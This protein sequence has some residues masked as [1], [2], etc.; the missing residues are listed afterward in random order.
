MGNDAPSK[1]PEGDSAERQKP[2]ETAPRG[3]AISTQGDNAVQRKLEQQTS[4]AA[5]RGTRENDP[6][7]TLD[8]GDGTVVQDRRPFA[9]AAAKPASDILATTKRDNTNPLTGQATENVI[10][11]RTVADKLQHFAI[12]AAAR[13]SNPEGQR[14][15]VQGCVDNVVGIAEGLNDAK[16]QTKSAAVVGAK[17][18]N[19]G[20]EALKDGSVT[21]FLMQ[22]NA[23]N[24]P[25]FKVVASSMQEML[26]AGAKDPDAFNKALSKLGEG[27]MQANDRYNAMSPEQ[28]GHV[29]GQVM[30]GGWTPEVSGA[31]MAVATTTTRIVDGV[32][33]QIDAAVWNR[34]GLVVKDIE[35]LSQNSPKMALQGKQLLAQLAQKYHFSEQELAAVGMPKGFLDG[36]PLGSNNVN[37]QKYIFLGEKTQL[38][39]PKAAERLGI[40]KQDLKAMTDKE[41]EAQGVARVE[42]YRQTF[43][44]SNPDLVPFADEIVVHHAI[45]QQVLKT[46]PGLFTPEE[47]NELSNFRGIPHDINSTVHLSGIRREWD[48]FYDLHPTINPPTR[49]QVI[50]EMRR[51]DAMFGNQ[52]VPPI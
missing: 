52:F 14:A 35:S 48:R 38:T 17:S 22:P 44:S 23:I 31:G 15:Y 21:R 6:P 9:K 2:K 43:F 36:V 29:Q 41:L 47:I 39:A 1:P 40:E 5:P 34:I 7:F 16:E 50:N 10:D 42:E 8:M 20:L 18:I 3:A 33:T 32:V 37:F 25:L 28:R 24:D 46:W 51:I 27:I 4:S 26:R 11:G 13:A 49:D 30:F 12:A 45:E 19:V